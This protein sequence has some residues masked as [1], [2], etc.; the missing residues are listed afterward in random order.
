[1]PS[2]IRLPRLILALAA[3]IGTT[4]AQSSPSSSAG[5]PTAGPLM[6]AEAIQ[7]AL[8]KNYS[9]KVS[10]FDAPIARAHLLTA[11]G[12]FDPALRGSYTTSEDGNP[13]STDP[14]GNRPPSSIIETDTYQ[15]ELAGTSPWGLSYSLGGFTQNRRLS[16]AFLDSYY[17]FAGV[18]FSQPL[19]RGFG[20]DANL[21]EVRIAR[22]NRGISGWDYRRTVADV[23]TAVIFAFHDLD[24]ARKNLA[25]AQRSRDLA[26]GL[27]DENERRFS[28][29]SL[30]EGDVTAARARVASREEAI[31]IAARAVE[32][33]GNFLKQLISDQ[34]TTDLLAWQLEIAEPTPLP[35]FTPNPAADFREAL[36]HR[37]DYQQA[38]LVLHRAET[39]R[40]YR[41]N[42]FL[43]RV[44]LVGSYGYNG[45][46]RDF[47]AS[48]RQVEDRESRS[49]SL[50]AVVSVPLTW[51]QER[52]RYRAARLTE[53]Q[54]E[55]QLQQLEQDILVRLG[56][57]A[58][59]IRTT[60]ERVAATRRS[61]ELAQQNLDAELKRL[62][63][64]TGNTFFVLEQ[65]EILATAEIRED[66]AVAEHQKALAEY[67]RQL[68]LTLSRHGIAIEE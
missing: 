24:F 42:Q 1:M 37:P 8:A 27:V 31:L 21:V 46:D 13:Q 49:Y 56:N 18:E 33:Q 61:R 51:A 4:F 16:P 63:S 36:E 48:R 19:L 38:L 23:V 2:L 39:Q 26:Q 44:D 62:R 3:G 15:L 41:R 40:R 43:P 54:A 32:D 12:A 53:Q 14:F 22:A 64:G 11:W 29:G 55:A 52:G 68:G 28:A 25:I 60:A 20:F 5:A 9:I 50:G 57:A 47:A 58:G 6:L 30:S 35:P 34:R 7:L 59:Q 65:Q 45:L 67:D 66:R 17:T 10:A